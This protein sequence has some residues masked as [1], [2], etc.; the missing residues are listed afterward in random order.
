MKNAKKLSVPSADEIA[1]KLPEFDAM[2]REAIKQSD[3]ARK[4]KQVNR[5]GFG[6][7]SNS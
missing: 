2:V 5:P 3:N 1:R 7:G 6:G 4:P